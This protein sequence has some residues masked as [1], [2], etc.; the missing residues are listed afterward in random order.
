M[1]G[2]FD[3]D[4]AVYRVGSICDHPWWE[5]R[6][7]RY[8]NKTELNLQLKEDGVDDT[9]VE[10][11][12]DPC[13][14]TVARNRAVSYIE[15]ITECFDDW[16]GF[17]SGKGNFRY[18]VA[19]IQPY[20]GNRIKLEKPFHYDNIRQVLV[21]VYD[22][23]LSSGQEADDDL[24]EAQG[25]DTCICSIDK[26]LDCVPGDHYDFVNEKFYKVN[27]IEANRSFF[28]Q[29]IIGDSTDNILGLYG[30]GKSSAYVKKIMKMDD[31]DEMFQLVKDMY[32]CRF[33]S[34]A[35]MFMKE[36]AELLWIRQR[37]DNPLLVRLEG[38]R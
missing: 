1:V 28:K 17:L 4:I 32:D 10:H 23:K 35:P 30:V 16:R 26:D 25:E 20:K 29:M 33:G 12:I 3:L 7:T 36:T 5:Y 21:D 22:C 2:L 31:T 11:G 8:T 38:S 14:E 27:E 13:S 15:E 6:G 19:T 37:R 9:S 24:G 18:K 34:Y